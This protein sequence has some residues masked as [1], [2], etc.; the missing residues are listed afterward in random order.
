MGKL[1]AGVPLPSSAF[2]HLEIDSFR[3]AIQFTAGKTEFP[4]ALIE[5]DYF[6]SL[7]L[8]EIYRSEVQTLVFKGGTSLN[9][10]HAGFY[11][12]SEDLD[13]SISV[14]SDAK[15]AARKIAIAP[16]KELVGES[17]DSR[18]EPFG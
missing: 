5:K 15:K 1:V 4:P 9:K 13:F 17:I 11:R 2:Q 7:V 16:A 18:S 3:D 14:S 8:R 12:L 6:C 10:V